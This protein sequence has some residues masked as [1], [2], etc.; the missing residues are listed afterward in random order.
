VLE[1]NENRGYGSALKIAKGSVSSFFGFKQGAQILKPKLIDVTPNDKFKKFGMANT[2][3]TLLD[4]DG[5]MN[6][7]T[8]L[9]PD[10]ARQHKQDVEDLFHYYRGIPASTKFD[11]NAALMAQTTS[12][13]Q[14]A[15]NESAFVS[16]IEMLTSMAIVSSGSV[17]EK[18]L[19]LFHLYSGKGDGD[20]IS[21]GY[22]PHPRPPSVDSTIKRM[23]EVKSSAQIG[24]YAITHDEKGEVSALLF[25]LKTK[26][27]AKSRKPTMSWN[28]FGLASI[29]DFGAIRREKSAEPVRAQMAVFG[30]KDLSDIKEKP[31]GKSMFNKRDQL[32]QIGYLTIEAK[33]IQLM[34][35]SAK[36]DDCSIGKLEITV[37]SFWFTQ[38]PVGYKPSEMK[39]FNPRV[40]VKTFMPNPKTATIKE[41]NSWKDKDISAGVSKSFF[42]YE[43]GESAAGLSGF[44][45]N[46]F[47]WDPAKAKRTSYKEMRFPSQLL[48]STTVSEAMISLHA[49]RLICIQIFQ[50]CLYP[51]TSRQAIAYAD[52]AFSRCRI[53]PCFTDAVVVK[54][55]SGSF[56]S[57]STIY[58]GPKLDPTETPLRAAYS[59]AL[60]GYETTDVLKYV[61]MAWDRAL[62]QNAGQIDLWFFTDELNKDLTLEGLIKYD[63]Y[64]GYDKALILRGR[65]AGDGDWFEYT[66]EFCGR[67]SFSLIN[68]TMSKV[69]YG[70]DPEKNLDLIKKKP[71]KD[72][73]LVPLD[74][75][76]DVSHLKWLSKEEFMS[77]M[78]GAP[79][80]A[81]SLRRMTSADTDARE[82]R[83]ASL[84]VKVDTG[85]GDTEF[86]G[87]VQVGKKILLEVW[88]HKGTGRNEFLGEVYI[89]DLE[90]CREMYEGS[91]PLQPATQESIKRDVYKGY[92]LDSKKVYVP[93]ATRDSRDK[94]TEWTTGLQGT[95]DKTKEGDVQGELSISARWVFPEPVDDNHIS[96]KNREE[97]TDPKEQDKYDEEVEKMRNTGRLSLSVRRGS[98][99]KAHNAGVLSS[100]GETADPFVKIWVYNEEG[101]KWRLVGQTKTQKSTEPVW[102]EMFEIRMYSG[103]YE[104]R[105]DR[106]GVTAGKRD[107]TVEIKFGPNDTAGHGV[108]LFENDSFSDLILKVQRA[109]ETLARR[110]KMSATGI[111]A[112]RITKYDGINIS[113]HRHIALGF[114]APPLFSLKREK[115]LDKMTEAAKIAMNREENR[116]K[117]FDRELADETNW[118][119]IDPG[120]TV[121]ETKHDLMDF[122]VKV[123]DNAPLREIHLRIIEHSRGYELTNPHYGEY[124]ENYREKQKLLGGSS[125]T[126]TCWA[127]YTPHGPNAETPFYYA[128]GMSKGVAEWRK[129]KFERNEEDPTKITVTWDVP[130]AG[131]VGSKQSAIVD[132]ELPEDQ[133]LFTGPG[134]GN[135]KMEKDV[136]EEM[137]KKREELYNDAITFAR[138]KVPIRQ[139]VT[140]LNR[141]LTDFYMLRKE[142]V[143][144][145]PKPKK[146]S[147]ENVQAKIQQAQME[148]EIKKQKAAAAADGM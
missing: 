72:T 127:P 103:S 12:A 89:N 66:L 69:L 8:E 29:K 30:N 7:M 63:P 76:N 49:V 53:A 40:E 80:L 126:A 58:E 3:P 19:L 122:K 10:Y 143:T 74:V 14:A 45:N 133:V 51:M 135:F 96:N 111:D 42:W 91:F 147:F 128:P 112:T 20:P 88:D 55:A 33:Y 108:K 104:A 141:S 31:D 9:F 25:V 100:R 119:P 132:A 64:K 92:H 59:K 61:N 54:G 125:D 56:P 99:L 32:V 4:Y 98:G 34:P 26:V 71:E 118:M 23:D 117:Q 136:D 22:Y 87:F 73:P 148:S 65:R 36:Y 16:V 140:D 67:N 15:Q 21:P 2:E 11:Q 139:I 131:T 107:T 134:A 101:K 106:F 113:P 82:S 144:G 37:K 5:F 6:F 84:T 105:M 57:L 110:E 121:R 39:S 13:K 116:E 38:M 75:E 97:I 138:Q 24:K 35:P 85:M 145:L 93:P 28:V 62:N 86:A 52:S 83:Q 18:A 90:E 41:V 27:D 77:G 115:G 95:K 1:L 94:T 79:V 17:C 44:K 60:P 129:G 109:I 78:T 142:E 43:P 130:S 70:G 124:K 47:V 102:S 50:R 123:K 81:E 68:N 48:R 146:I 137:K 120:D 114:V 46:I